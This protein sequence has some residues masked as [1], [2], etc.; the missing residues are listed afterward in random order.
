VA[1]VEPPTDETPENVLKFYTEYYA[2]DNIN[3]D[4]NTPNNPPEVVATKAP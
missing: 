1:A 2:I 3:W 4:L